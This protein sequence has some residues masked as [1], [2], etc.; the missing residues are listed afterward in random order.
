[1][2]DGRWRTVAKTVLPRPLRRV[3]RGA[4]HYAQR[5]GRWAVILW[6]IRGVQWT[7]QWT[8]LRS[9]LASLVLS[10]RSLLEW[11]DPILLEDAEVSVRGIGRFLLRK[12]SDDL[13]HVLPWREKAIFNVLR[14]ILKPGDVFIDAG[15]NIGIYTVV[16]SRLVAPGG[17]VI[18]VEMMP[19]TVER[20]EAHIRLNELSNVTVVPQALTDANGEVVVATVESGK[21]GK[22]SIAGRDEAD[23]ADASKAKIS[24]TTTTIDDIT[25]GLEQVQLMKMDLEGVEFRALRGGSNLLSRLDKLVYESWG[26]VRKGRDPVDELL[27]S[28]GFSLTRI[29]GNNWLASRQDGNG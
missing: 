14:T 13:W 8:L 25:R 28:A 24:V 3:M 15:A 10:M 20:L 12:R 23:R 5:V 19:D 17:R 7:D 18:S 27:E 11:Q 16:A 26:A 4:M 9:A 21:Y 22:A 1:M 6:Q 2:A 29:D